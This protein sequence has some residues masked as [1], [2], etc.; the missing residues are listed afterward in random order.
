MKKPRDGDTSV[1][2]YSNG[3]NK[4]VY[5]ETS[6]GALCKNKECE[7]Y[8]SWEDYEFK[9]AKDDGFRTF[10]I[11]RECGERIYMD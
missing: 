8:N 9:D 4:M 6:E 2:V 3:T 10:Y 5:I 1:T 11:C 7:N